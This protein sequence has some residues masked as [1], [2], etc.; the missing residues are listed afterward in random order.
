MVKQVAQFFNEVRFELAKVT[1]PTYN[2]LVG[3]VIIVMIVVSFFA[4]YF[5]FVDLLLYKIAE[6]IF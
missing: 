6:R 1:W 2:E 5:G 3:S 4:V